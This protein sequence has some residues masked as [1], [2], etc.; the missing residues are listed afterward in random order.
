MKAYQLIILSVLIS[1][2]TS[3]N[4]LSML[5]PKPQLEVNANLGKNV[6]QDKSMI[7]VESGKT[8]QKADNIS[9]DSQVN[10]ETINNIANKLEWWQWLAILICV[11]AALPS[12][13]EMYSGFKIVLIDA[14]QLIVIPCKAFRDFV[15]VLFGK[16]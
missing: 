10:A 1:S 9:N 14:L 11:G 8:E 13:K 4:P 16:S 3:L 2:C 7:K 15:F 5:T 6:E 12:F